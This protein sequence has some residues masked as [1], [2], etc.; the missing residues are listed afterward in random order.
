MYIIYIVHEVL[1]NGCEWFNIE[2][3]KVIME[4]LSL[5]YK[6]YIYFGP[7]FVFV[8]ALSKLV[9][10]QRLRI[11]FFYSL[12]YLFMGLGMLQVVSYSMKPYPGYWYVSHL[13]IPFTFG[14]P[15]FLY[16]RFRFLIQGISIRIHP[17][18]PV[19]FS[20]ITLF[21]S[22]GPFLGG[23]LSFV[24][25]HAEL[26]PLL[27][28]SF[29]NL[30]VYYKIVHLINFS[31]KVILCAGLLTLLLKTIYPWQDSDKEMSMQAR[32][33]YI[34]TIMMF[35]TSA[36]GFTGDIVSFEFSKAS[37]A[38]VNTVTLGVFLASQYDPGYY[39][40]FKHLR[41]KKKYAVSKVKGI[42]VMSVIEQLSM[43][44]NENQLY[45]EE[46]LSIK[47]VAEMLDINHQQLSEILNREL[48]KSF[49]SY[50]NDFK[51]SEARNLLVNEPELPVI[52]IA[53]SVGFNSVRT[54]NRVFA[55]STGVTPVEYRNRHLKK[56]L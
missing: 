46:K 52:R 32:I 21:I 3:G 36:L 2:S 19:V 27:D 54:F 44:M 17:V 1:T 7:I 39:A 50:V 20:V 16:L 28:Q 14:T 30:P 6:Q 25:E 38:M 45:L 55:K 33:A 29:M 43:L 53:M 35:L 49:S 40:I 4:I 34:F 10:K 37:I 15:L 31:G 24:R 8:L 12:S 9:S 18:I 48:G 23:E 11:N 13:L 22:A 47:D 5:I 51:I 26:R 42:D 41:Q 56:K